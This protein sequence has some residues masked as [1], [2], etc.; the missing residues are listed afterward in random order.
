MWEW[1]E[2]S[3]V[4]G[5]LVGLFSGWFLAKRVPNNAS[6]KPR[7]NLKKER[8]PKPPPPLE[9]NGSFEGSAKNEVN[10]LSKRAAY[11]KDVV[12]RILDAGFFCHVAFVRGDSP[13]ENHPVILPMLYGRRGE[14]IFLHG[15]SSNRMLKRLEEVPL[16]L[17]VAIVDGLVYARSLFHHSANYRSVVVFGRAKRIE[18]EKEKNEALRFITENSMPGRWDV[19]RLPNKSELHTTTVLRLQIETASAKIREGP[20][21]DDKKD[22]EEMNIWAGVLPVHLTSKEPIPDPTLKENILPPLHITQNYKFE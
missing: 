19:A 14:E 1:D 22:M 12:F 9:V 20:P 8:V 4:V 7:L 5:I 6:N 21:V 2:L 11:D 13:E 18:D 3:V 15:H 16:C 10:R 17:S